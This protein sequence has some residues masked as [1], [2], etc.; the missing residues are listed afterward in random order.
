[1][2]ASEAKEWIEDTFERVLFNIVW[3]NDEPV[4]II[5]TVHKDEKFFLS[6]GKTLVDI[7][8]ELEK[9]NNNCISNSA[10]E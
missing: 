2:L 1:V 7:Q 6:K 8:Q 4:S 9:W 10:D 5:V 3:E